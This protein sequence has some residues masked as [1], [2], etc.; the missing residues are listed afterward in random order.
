GFPEARLRENLHASWS[1]LA[2]MVRLLEL[3]RWHVAERLEQ[4]LMVVPCDP[5]ERRELDVLERLPRPAPPD[6]FRLEQSDHRL[7]QSVIVRIPHAAHR[8]LDARLRQ[9]FGVP[10]RQILPEFKWS[11]QHYRCEPIVEPRRAPRPVFASQ[12]SCEA[13]C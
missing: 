13:G 4:A 2:V 1:S 8:S 7:G 9:P 3:G 12:E 10:D 5:L 11:S 6:L